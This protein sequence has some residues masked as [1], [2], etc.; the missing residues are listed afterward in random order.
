M[1]SFEKS[2]GVQR[3][4]KRMEAF[5]DTLEECQL[6]DIG[7]SGGNLSETN[8]RERLDRGVAN[9]KWITLFPMGNI[10][11]LPYSTSDHCPPL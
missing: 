5:R 1:Y 11:H 9:E 8:I 2:G 6:M 7:Y 10:Q 4:Q 3:D